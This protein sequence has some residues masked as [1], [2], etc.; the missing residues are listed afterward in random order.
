MYILQRLR[1]SLGLTTISKETLSINTFGRE[2][3]GKQ[4]VR[5][6]YND[7]NIC[8]K[9]YVVPV[10]CAALNNQKTDT[11]IKQYPD[12][13]ALYLADFHR[14]SNELKSIL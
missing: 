7:L 14:F 9:T 3:G 6:A 1:D 12:I 5:S 8:V 13:A 2:E 4:C 10:V 11:A